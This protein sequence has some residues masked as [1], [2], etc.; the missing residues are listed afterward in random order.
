M[1]DICRYSL[2]T[3]CTRSSNI[4]KSSLIGSNFLTKIKMYETETPLMYFCRICAMQ[5]RADFC[6]LQ[7][8]FEVVHNNMSLADM[9]RYCLKRQVMEGDGFPSKI[10]LDCKTRLIATY[11]FHNLCE[12]SEEYFAANFDQNYINVDIK[13]FQQRDIDYN[14]QCIEN[15]EADTEYINK[16]ESVDVKI[17]GPFASELVCIDEGMDINTDDSTPNT[18]RSVDV[19]QRKTGVKFE[20]FECKQSF[21]A[22]KALRTHM[23]DHESIRKPFEC[24]TCKIRFVHVNS[25]FRHRSKHTKNIHNCEYCS[26]SFNTLPLI[27]QHLQDAHKHQLKAYKCN[28]CSEEFA[29]QFLLVWHVEWHKKAKQLTCTTC[30]ATFFND[31]K[32]KKHIRE[33]HA[34]KHLNYSCNQVMDSM[35]ITFSGHLCSECGKSFKTIHMLASHQMLHTTEKP[36]GC[37]LCP[38]RFKWKAALKTHMLVHTGQKQHVCDICGSTFTTKGSMKKHKSKHNHWKT[39]IT[40]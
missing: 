2:F 7:D 39:I 17:E 1:S 26:E 28:L 3:S 20:C 25:W 32:L 31:R 11:E 36:F 29:L 38:S 10:C 30:E 18:K 24:T 8:L 22:L 13:P 5:S 35:K 27:K 23:D 12:C 6:D 40:N 34:S 33:N 14:I 37:D 21:D 4:K 9:L 15:I 19:T 16:F